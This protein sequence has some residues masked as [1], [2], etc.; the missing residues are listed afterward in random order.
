MLITMCALPDPGSY[1]K[2]P[3]QVN[4]ALGA[5][6]IVEA[7]TNILGKMLV[8]MPT[9][10]FTIGMTFVVIFYVFLWIG[11][12][13]LLKADP[14]ALKGLNHVAIVSTLFITGFVMMVCFFVVEMIKIFAG[15]EKSS[16]TPK[17]STSSTKKKSPK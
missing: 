1:N 7:I 5:G 3:I 6:K 10:K 17:K 4:D 15:N 14:V 9:D 13:L 11:E 16:D 12:Y 8:K 2:R